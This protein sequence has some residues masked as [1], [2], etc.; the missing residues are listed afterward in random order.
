LGERVIEALTIT[1]SL[2]Q[3]ADVGHAS[4][5]LI[6]AS[7]HYM[8][9]EVAELL[10]PILRQREHRQTAASCMR[11]HSRQGVSPVSFFQQEAKG[12]FFCAAVRCEPDVDRCDLSG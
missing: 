6:A 11:R 1:R 4:P 12:C 8:E 7:W 5:A 9:R 10:P 3:P 2:G